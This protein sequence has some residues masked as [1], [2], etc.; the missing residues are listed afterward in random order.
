[1]IAACVRSRDA[2]LVSTRLT[3]VL[4]VSSAT[5]IRVALIAALWLVAKRDA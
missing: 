2:S 3:C 1:M 4:T 5:T